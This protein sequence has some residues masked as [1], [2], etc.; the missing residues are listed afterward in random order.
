MTVERGIHL[1][2]PYPFKKDVQ[3]GRLV[4]V[5]VYGYLIVIPQKIT[6]TLQVQNMKLCNIHMII[7]TLKIT[8]QAVAFTLDLSN[9]LFSCEECMKGAQH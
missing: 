4:G 2:P 8:T 6:I 1:A 7:N 9:E 3:Y 5:S